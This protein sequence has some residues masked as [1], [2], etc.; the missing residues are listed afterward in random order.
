[1]V[2]LCLF[3]LVFF[4]VGFLFIWFVYFFLRVFAS[5]S[6][7]S[8]AAF[9]CWEA[10]LPA[11]VQVLVDCTTVAFCS[12]VE[13]VKERLTMV[14]LCEGFW[15]HCC[16]MGRE[17]SALINGQ[18]VS[19]V[20]SVWT[21]L[22]DPLLSDTLTFRNMLGLCFGNLS[23]CCMSCNIRNPLIFRKVWFVPVAVNYD[24]SA[25]KLHFWT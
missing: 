20:C 6:T 25:P 9:C 16:L 1:M 7:R 22:A 10:M 17:A 5:L 18:A 13:Y 19:T 15:M 8:F 2:F 23:G 4:F 12:A 21:V 14:S 24:S 11:E 3:G